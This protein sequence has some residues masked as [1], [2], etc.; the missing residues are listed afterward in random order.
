MTDAAA[1]YLMAA[2]WAEVIVILI[3]GVVV[4][5]RLTRRLKP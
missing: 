2:V 1:Y 3:S 4:T 5:N